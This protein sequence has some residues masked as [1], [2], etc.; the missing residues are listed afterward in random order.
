LRTLRAERD[1]AEVAATVNPIEKAMKEFG[2]RMLEV[3]DDQT[4]R[5][6]EIRDRRR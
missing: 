5:S 6:G 1:D 3:R 4:R 2:E